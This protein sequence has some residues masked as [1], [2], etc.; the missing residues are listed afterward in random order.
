MDKEWNKDGMKEKMADLMHI[1]EAAESGVLL[2]DECKEMGYNPKKVISILGAIG[3]LEHGQYGLEKEDL[4]S[5]DDAAFTDADFR[6]KAILRCQDILLT[7]IGTASWNTKYPDVPCGLSSRSINALRRESCI[8]FY[9][10]LGFSD[11]HL[12]RLRNLG[13]GCVE[14]IKGAASSIAHRMFGMSAEDLANVVYSIPGD[15]DTETIKRAC[16]NISVWDIELE[17]IVRNR[18][19]SDMCMRDICRGSVSLYDLLNPASSLFKRRIQ[20]IGQEKLHAAREAV[21]RFVMERFG[22]G[23]GSLSKLLYHK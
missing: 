6:R 13:A 15:A 18:I 7:E 12:S 22:M 3:R 2:A 9:D 16:M 20:Q 17:T 14:E 10:L 1:L 11:V 19:I 5:L 21:N 23:I 8:T 4:I